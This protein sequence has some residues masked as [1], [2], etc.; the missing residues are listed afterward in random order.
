MKVRVLFYGKCELVS[1]D[2]VLSD[3]DY[4]YEE[5]VDGYDIYSN[6]DGDYFAVREDEMMYFDCRLS[7]DETY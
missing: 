6:T 7:I 5:T 3:L 1:R 4:Q 2:V